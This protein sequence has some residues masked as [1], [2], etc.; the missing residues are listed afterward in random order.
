MAKVKRNIYYKGVWY[1]AGAT[2]PEEMPR[3]YT[4]APEEKVVVPKTEDKNG[5]PKRR[6]KK[7]K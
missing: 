5:A 6:S 3:A 1:P 2:A 7:A 4:D